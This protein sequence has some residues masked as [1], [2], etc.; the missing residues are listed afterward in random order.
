M[1]VT[2]SASNIVWHAHQVDRR[3]RERLNGH[4]GCVLWFTGLS[5]AGKSTIANAV[6][7]ALHARGVHTYLLDG[8]NI[9]FGLNSNL[10]FSAADRSE[11]IR[12]IGEVAR[13]M[14]DAGLVTLSAF[15]S[16]Y[17]ADRARVR[18]MLGPGEFVEILCQAS[19][20][21][22]EAR[23]PTGLYRRARAG[24]IEAFTGI[25]APYEAPAAPELV[26][27]TEHADAASLADAVLAYL[28]AHA[29]L[30]PPAVE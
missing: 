17:R 22:C 18:A 19:L 25:D 16:P 14:A 4:R 12:R 1:T 8:D 3:A 26:L 24:E 20:A 2:P 23:D 21:T 5:G 29:L 6:E 7:T 15:I 27:D 11:N 10:G 9:R 30:T 28:S 13:L